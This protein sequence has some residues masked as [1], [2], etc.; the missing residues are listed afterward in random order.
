ML[1]ES[2]E[3]LKQA[4]NILMQGVPENININE[5]VEELEE[6]EGIKNVHH[7][8]IWRLNENNI[9]FEGI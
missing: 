7:V 9:F 3:I 8:H 5:L 4:I 1:K 6:I 2:Y